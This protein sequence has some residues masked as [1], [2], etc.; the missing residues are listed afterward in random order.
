MCPVDLTCRLPPTVD[1][2]VIALCADYVRRAE[3][4]L[5]DETPTR[6]K[7]E[8]R[9]INYKLADAVADVVERRLIPL[10]IEEIGS[11]IGFASSKIEGMGES[12][13]KRSKAKIKVNIAKKLYLIP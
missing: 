3:A 8:L 1:A 13:Y 10:F 11:R 6:M 12:V 9:Y 7:V 5:S 2:L 4:I